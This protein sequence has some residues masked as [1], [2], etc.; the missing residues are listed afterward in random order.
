[1]QAGVIS[2]LTDHVKDNAIFSLPFLLH[3]YPSLLP[4]CES[5]V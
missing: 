3:F 4:K 1:M 5:L 2:C